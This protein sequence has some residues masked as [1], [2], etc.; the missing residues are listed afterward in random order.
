MIVSNTLTLYLVLLKGRLLKELSAE[1][2]TANIYV[3]V[4]VLL[5]NAQFYITHG[6]SSAQVAETAVTCILLSTA[7]GVLS[8]TQALAG[9]FIQNQYSACRVGVESGAFAF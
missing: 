4:D 8:D 9:C 2:V 5:Y 6:H 7:K 1:E 3:M